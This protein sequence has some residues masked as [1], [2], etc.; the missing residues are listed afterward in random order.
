MPARAFSYYFSVFW[1]GGLS[2]QD[3]PRHLIPSLLSP[4][5]SF[6][7]Q[8][9]QL[10]NSLLDPFLNPVQISMPPWFDI[11]NQQETS[12]FLYFCI[13]FCPRPHSSCCVRSLPGYSCSDYPADILLCFSRLN[14]FLS[15]VC[16]SL[17]NFSILLTLPIGTRN[18]SS[19]DCYF[20][21]WL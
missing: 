16:C 21:H 14:V 9:L 11:T 4:Q 12:N 5:L 18:G 13:F 17:L 8:T 3:F 7:A 10:Q 15:L 6:R 20:G 19:S 1:G 2:W